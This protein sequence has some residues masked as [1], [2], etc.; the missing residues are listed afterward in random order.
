LLAGTVRPSDG[1]AR[2]NGADLAQLTRSDLRKAR[3]RVGFVHQDHSLVPTLRVSQN[4]IA[5]RLGQHDFFAAVRSMLAPRNE[6]IERTF[7]LL[8]RVGIPEKLFERTDRLSGG[9][10]QRVALA[11]A[12]FQE[13]AALL[14]DE[15]VASVDPTRARDLIQLMINVSAEDKLTLVAALHDLSIAREF[16]PRCVGMR[17]GCI[18]FDQPTADVTPEAWDDLYRLESTGDE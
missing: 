10:Q 13:P 8:D 3:A 4:V 2:A 12:L 16:F 18:V 15:P 5:G 17:A 6:D 11:R 14:A 1:S 7:R 9:Q